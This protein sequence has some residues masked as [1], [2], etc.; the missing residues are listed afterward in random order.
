MIIIKQA[1]DQSIDRSLIGRLL[2]AATC[3]L[4]PSYNSH[5]SPPTYPTHPNHLLSLSFK[6][7]CTANGKLYLVQ[8][9]YKLK[10]Y[11]YVTSPT[12]YLCC[13]HLHERKNQIL[14]NCICSHTCICRVFIIEMPHCTVNN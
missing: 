6:C 12:L 5:Y 13:T 9:V 2:P 14:F 10:T 4:R 1:I 7:F 3:V 8:L 11:I